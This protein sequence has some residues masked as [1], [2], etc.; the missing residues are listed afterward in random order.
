MSEELFSMSMSIFYAIKFISLFSLPFL[1][2]DHNISMLMMMM[3]MFYPCIRLTL[4]CARKFI[5]RIF[6]A[7]YLIYSRRVK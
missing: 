2:F 1:I 3:M 4:L 6:T 5:F 7:I